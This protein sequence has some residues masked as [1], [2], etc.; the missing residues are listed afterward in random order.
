[1][2]PWRIFPFI[3][4]L[5][6]IPL[7]F[8][9]HRSRPPLK[10]TEQ[11]VRQFEQLVANGS[12][13]SPER[14]KQ[15]SAIYVR[16]GPYPNDAEIRLITTGDLVAEDWIKGDHAQAETKWNDDCG[17]IDSK[18]RYKSPIERIGCIA[19]VQQ[20]PLARVSSSST[21]KIEWKIEDPPTIRWAT[22]KRAIEYLIMM[23]DKTTDAT[24]R[25]NAEKTIKILKQLDSGCAPRNSAC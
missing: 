23:R 15:A 11:V 2:R 8:A 7:L 10:P 3:I 12:F 18:L 20:F 1:M 21:G 13:L 17:T 6:I 9:Q 19:M 25:K 14:W 5:L 4:P 24:I 22:P 16:S